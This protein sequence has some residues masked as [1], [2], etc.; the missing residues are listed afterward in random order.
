MKLALG[1]VQFGLSYGLNEAPSIVEEQEAKAIL[2]CAK[3]NG[4]DFLDTA[5]S[6]GDSESVL[7]RIGVEAWK[8]VSKL[9]QIPNTCVD[10]EKWIKSQVDLSI[11]R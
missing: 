7:G 8:V 4:I 9:P 10:V 6:Y 2:D 1:T 3:R 11:E 5:I